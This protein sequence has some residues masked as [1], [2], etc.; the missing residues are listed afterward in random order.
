MPNIYISIFQLVVLYAAMVFHEVAHGMMAYKLGDPT[1]KLAGRLSFN[2]LKHIDPFGTVILPLLLLLVHSPF[3][4]CYAQP[5]PFNPA[6]FKNIKRDTAL[7]G[8]AGPLTNFGLAIFFG[9]LARL[10]IY[11]NLISAELLLLIFIIV[12]FNLLLAI[13]NLAPFP[14]FD[15]H[16]LVFSL[17]P[18]KFYQLKNF[19]ISN[20]LI[21]LIIWI[22]FIFPYF[23][24][25]WVY[26]LAAIL[27]GQG[28]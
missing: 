12:L 26:N 4:V 28:F 2:P 24:A 21:L 18:E 23:L 19:L 25:P 11:F 27:V 13:F 5:V 8:L 9:L 17:V 6:N 3:V 15:G 1:A 10:L 22:V 7:T 16:H 14:P 20:Y